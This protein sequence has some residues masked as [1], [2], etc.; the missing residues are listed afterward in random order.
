[1][2]TRAL[3]YARYLVAWNARF[4]GDTCPAKP[5]TSRSITVGGDPGILLAYDC[6]ILINIAGTVHEG[7]GYWFGFRD[8]SVQAA[9]DPV[10]RNAFL[11]ILGSV[12]FHR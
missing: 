5:H 12:R 11:Q 10:D 7:L 9:T 4:H 3:A 6:G 2:E 8:P 1:M